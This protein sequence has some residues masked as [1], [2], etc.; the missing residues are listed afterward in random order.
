[1][2]K[3]NYVKGDATSPTGD[4]YKCICHICNDIGAWGAGF[5]LA[6]SKKWKGPE[7]D[8]RYYASKKDT[9]LG[10]MHVC[11]VEENVCVVNMVAQHG[12][13]WDRGVPPISYDA[14]AVCLEKVAEFILVG[15]TKSTLKGSVHMPRIGCGLAGGE[16]PAVEVIIIDKLCRLNIPVFVYD[17]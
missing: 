9:K 10:S 7:A 12:I 13:G 1:M 17:L 8:Y 11:T 14:L 4:G 5:V 6:L 2:T 16:W 3:I 15:D